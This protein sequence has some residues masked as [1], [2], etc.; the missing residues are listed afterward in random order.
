MNTIKSRT[1]MAFPELPAELCRRQ[2]TIHE[3]I[4]KAT[5]IGDRE[6][7]YQSMAL[8]PWVR[9]LKQARN[10]ADDFFEFYK[11]ELPQFQKCY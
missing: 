6:A 10:I 9:D 8:D 11:E 2:I 3:M 1:Y 4:V 7:V 5:I